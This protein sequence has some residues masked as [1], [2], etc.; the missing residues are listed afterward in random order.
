M[1]PK[2]ERKAMLLRLFN[3]ETEL[4]DHAKD[5][6]RIAAEKRA[7]KAESD[8][9]DEDVKEEIKTEVKSENAED[10]EGSVQLPVETPANDEVKVET[11][12]GESEGGVKVEGDSNGVKAEEKAS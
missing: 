1:L 8:K 6:E 3:D 10:E 9:M 12:E 2:E 7:E 11:A 4:V 5:R